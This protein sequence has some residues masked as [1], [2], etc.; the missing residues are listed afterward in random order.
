IEGLIL[1]S[2]LLAF[3]KHYKTRKNILASNI[4][5]ISKGTKF[6]IGIEAE[7]LTRNPEVQEETRNDPMMLKKVSYHWYKEVVRTM[8]DTADHLHKLTAKPMCV[9]YGT[10]DQI[11][12][13]EVTHQLL[14]SLNLDEVYFKAWPLLAHEIHNEPER[15]AVMRYILSFLNNRVYAAGYLVEDENSLK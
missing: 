8:K 3:Q 5:D 15:E 4:G 1:L 14:H 7:V 6:D 12:D 9:M 10:A 13:T 2:P 11:S